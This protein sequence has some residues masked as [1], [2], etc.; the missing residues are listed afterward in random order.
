MSHKKKVLQKYL[1]ARV[2]IIQQPILIFI[3]LFYEKKK[4]LTHKE[5]EIT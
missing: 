3:L 5:L 2:Y 1:C 4:V